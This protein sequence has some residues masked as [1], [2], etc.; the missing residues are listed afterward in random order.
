MRTALRKM[1]NS[2][3]FIVPKPLLLQIGAVAGA[4]LEVSVE[5]G[6]IVA[7]PARVGPRVGWAAAAEALTAVGDDALAWPAFANDGDSD[8]TW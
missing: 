6:R 3:G 8:L 7:A 1:G 5:D 4:T 2:T